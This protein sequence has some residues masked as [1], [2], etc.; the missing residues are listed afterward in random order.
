[1]TAAEPSGSDSIDSTCGVEPTVRDRFAS[2]VAF[3]EWAVICRSIGAGRQSV[4]LRKGGLDEGRDGFQVAHRQFWLFPTQFHQS[5]DD[6]DPAFHDLWRA[7]SS[8]APSPGI[9]PISVG[10]VVERVVRLEHF[11]AAAALRGLHGW[12]ESVV[13]KRFEYREPGLFALFVRAYCASQEILLK[14]EPRF[15][16]CRSWVELTQPVDAHVEPAI[17]DAAHI[18]ARRRWDAALGTARSAEARRDLA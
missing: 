16:G 13:R 12:S 9:L 18:A 3:K 8:N 7:T 10:V 17:D 1:M 11:D 15:A 5:S 6:V 14:A 2:N 4:I